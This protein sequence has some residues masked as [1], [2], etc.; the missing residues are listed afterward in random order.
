MLR[1]FVLAATLATALPAGATVIYDDGQAHAIASPV[2]DSVQVFGGSSLA[3]L[4]GAAIVSNGAFDALLVGNTAGAVTI[5]GGTITQT[6]PG[7]DAVATGS[8]SAFAVSGG[9]FLGPTSLF[10]T[11]GGPGSI[12]TIS[13]GMWSGNWFVDVV[14][15]GSLT[16]LGRL[17]ITPEGSTPDGSYW[18][19]AGT[20]LSGELFGASVLVP[21]GPGPAQDPADGGVRFGPSSVP[22]PPSAT[23]LGLGLL[24]LLGL[25]RRR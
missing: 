24:G 16:I 4:P 2:N 21:E 20:L 1:H 9:T 7:G 23:L 19:I 13:G 5:T 14:E 10:Y 15:G 6:G 12:A 3:V 25:L 11:A 18:A 8:D 22:T 17:T